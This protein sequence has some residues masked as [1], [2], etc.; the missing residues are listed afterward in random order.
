MR[1]I[2]TVLRAILWLPLCWLFDAT[3]LESGR[4]ISRRANSI[5]RRH[6]LRILVV[7]SGVGIWW[8]GSHELR[9][10]LFNL[11]VVLVTFAI[12]FFILFGGRKKRSRKQRRS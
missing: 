6:A 9:L 8:F 5:W 7:S 1:I 4:T 12:S 10:Q 2:V 3:V 11:L